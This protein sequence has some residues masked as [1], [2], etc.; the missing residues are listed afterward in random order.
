MT[1]KPVLLAGTA[2]FSAS[3]ATVGLTDPERP[4]DPDART[5]RQITRLDADSHREPLYLI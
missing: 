2:S 4:K 1:A 5:A 3:A